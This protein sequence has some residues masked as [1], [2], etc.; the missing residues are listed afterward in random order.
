MVYS[1][2]PKHKFWLIPVTKPYSILKQV[3]SSLQFY[4]CAICECG[5]CDS[6]GICTIPALVLF[7]T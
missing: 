7:D 5:L 6:D 2:V 1:C 4:V 3:V